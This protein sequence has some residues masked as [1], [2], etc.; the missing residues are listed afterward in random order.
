MKILPLAALAAALVLPLQ[1]Q[2]ACRLVTADVP[3]TMEG[4]RPLV[5]AKIGGKPVRLLLDSGAFGSS[6]TATFAAQEKL[7]SITAKPIG[8]LVPSSASTVTSGVVGHDT[9]TGIVVAP[10]FEFGGSV[11][12][13]VRFLTIRDIGGAAGL[14]GQN[15]LKTSDDEYDFKNGLLRLVRPQDCETTALAYWVKPGET[16]SMIP[17][18]GEARTNAH[19]VALITINGQMMRAYFDTG[20]S[21]SFITAHAAAKAGVRTTDPGVTLVGVSH[22]LDGDTKTWVGAF[23]SIKIG[24]EEI[25]NGKLA[26]GES[27]AND[28]DVLIGADFFMAH[29]VYVANSQGKLYFSYSGGPVFRTSAPPKAAASGDPQPR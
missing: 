10:T 24:D 25:K 16:Y 22:G 21:T 19:N 20:A 9:M 6:L 26:I 11:F 15:L 28:F 8:S 2:A 23:A 7:A 14:V 29:H 5:A 27:V 13:N 1:A 17:L 3:V 4:L 12:P 18:D